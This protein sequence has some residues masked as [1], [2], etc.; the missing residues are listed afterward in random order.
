ML[1]ELWIQVS[2]LTGSS[3]LTSDF[4]W[5]QDHLSENRFAPVVVLYIYEVV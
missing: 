3:A 2:I 4:N 1:D 5:S